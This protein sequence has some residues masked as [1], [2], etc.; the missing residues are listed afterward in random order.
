MSCFCILE[1]NPLS[2]ASF[3]NIFFHSED[4]LFVYDFLCCAK[5][6]KFN[7]THCLFLFLFH[8]SRR[9]I[10]KKYCCNLCQRLFCLFSS[11]SFIVSSL[12]FR[13]LSILSL[14]L[15]V[16]LENV[17]I[18]FFYMWLSSFPSTILLKRLFSIIYSC[19]LSCKLIG[20]RCMSLF[21]G[22]LSCSVDLYV[23]FCASSVLF[24][25]TVP[26]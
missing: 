10:Q 23:C 17:L 11:R 22:F 25:I 8:Y 24:L 15:C 5:A 9:Q 20:H 14:F 16:M 26:L 1:I 2:V 7:R 6:F 18:S 12:I 4:C 13:S 21:L 19:L 3:S